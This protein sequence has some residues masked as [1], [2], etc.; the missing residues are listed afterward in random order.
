MKEY[1]IAILGATGAV[2][3][4]LI[5]ELAQSKIPVKKIK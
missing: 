3:Q 1:V 5:T 4:R 2:G